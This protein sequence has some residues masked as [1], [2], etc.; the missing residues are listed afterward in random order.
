[1]TRQDII[2]NFCIINCFLFVNMGLNTSNTYIYPRFVC[3]YKCIY[4]YIH[5]QSLTIY[6]YIHLQY[7]Y[8]Y[9]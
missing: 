3:D 6:I 9:I 8:I 2:D 7:I 1:M 5:L 4:I